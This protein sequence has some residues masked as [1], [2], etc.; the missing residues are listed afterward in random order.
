MQEIKNAMMLSLFDGSAGSGTASGDGGSAAPAAAQQESGDIKTE[1]RYGKP[2][3][4]QAAAETD[5]QVTSN[6]LDAKNKAYKDLIYGEYKDQHRA[7]M[8]RV[9]DK[10]FK[11][12]KTLEESL[13]KSQPIIDGL[14]AR[15]GVKDLDELTKAIDEDDRYWED[16]AD[17]NGMTVE[18]FK[19]FQKLEAQNK[20]LLAEQQAREGKEKAEQQVQQ[21]MQEADEMKQMYPSFDLQA[22]VQNDQFARLLEKG[23]PMLHAYRLIH[24]D[25]ILTDMATA[26]AVNAEQKVAA[27]I[28]A[29]GQRPTENGTST[30]SAVIYKTD[31]NKLTKKDR[32]NVAERVARGERISF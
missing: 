4:S 22:E 1:I 23:I 13:A 28:R 3:E 5:V 29:R 30:A 7:E 31:V 9:I 32:A 14:M 8:Q 6:T 2:D 20:A 27:N 19:R 25:E 26:S 15:Y 10:R 12:T 17:A 24:M 21:W 16:A 11:E 18:Q